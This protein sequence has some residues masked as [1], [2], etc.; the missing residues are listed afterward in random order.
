MKTHPKKSE[1]YKVPIKGYMKNRMQAP[2]HLY[3]ISKHIIFDSEK[4]YDSQES[5]VYMLFNCNCG[6]SNVIFLRNIFS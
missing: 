3:C 1:H 2:N 6:G 4:K 5:R